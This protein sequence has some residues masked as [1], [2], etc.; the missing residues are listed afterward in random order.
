LI[1]LLRAR[2]SD[3]VCSQLSRGAFFKIAYR[4]CGITLTLCLFKRGGR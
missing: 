3:R 1:S 4:A 2:V